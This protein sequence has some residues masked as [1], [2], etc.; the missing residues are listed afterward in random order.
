[1]WKR[2][3]PKSSLALSLLVSRVRADDQH[4][5]V[6]LD[7]AAAVTHGFD[8]SSDFHKKARQATAKRGSAATM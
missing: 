3:L 4:L 7:H 8:G 2:G 5:A 1:M 6:P